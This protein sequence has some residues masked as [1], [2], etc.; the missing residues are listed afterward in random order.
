MFLEI[1]VSVHSKETALILGPL[2]WSIGGV[3]SSGLTGVGSSGLTGP[4]GD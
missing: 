2:G 3:G 4:K 1:T